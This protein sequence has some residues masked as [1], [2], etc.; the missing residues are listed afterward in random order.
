[1]VK[2]VNKVDQFKVYRR[3]I[4]LERL[5]IIANNDI[6]VVSPSTQDIQPNRQV[7]GWGNGLFSITFVHLGRNF[8]EA[9]LWSATHPHRRKWTEGITRRQ[10]LSREWSQFFET[11]YYPKAFSSPRTGRSASS[12]EFLLTHV[13]GCLIGTLDGDYLHDFRE[14]IREPIK[15][16]ALINDAQIDVLDDYGLLL[17]LSEG[18]V[19]TFPLHVLEAMYLLA[20]IAAHTSYFKSGVCV[21]R[22]DVCVFKARSAIEYD[23]PQRAR[24]KS[25]DV[26]TVAARRERYAVNLQGIL[27]PRAVELDSLPAHKALRG[28]RK[29]FAI[30][31]PKALDTQGLLG[32]PTNRSNLQG[33]KDNTRPK[34]VAIYRIENKI[35]P[36]YDGACVVA[37]RESKTEI[38]CLD[39]TEFA[40]YT[41][42]VDRG[43]LRG[44]D[45]VLHDHVRSPLRHA[46]K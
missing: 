44:A 36:C 26:P 46:P 30:I 16:S 13:G 6:C 5:L 4:P 10:D 33:G 9:T 45:V 23:R 7:R 17:V 27:R 34:P 28:V 41:E 35:F 42:G 31:Y 12:V 43:G 24:Q 21:G 2:E 32:P 3:P 25:A 11:T 20:G 40:F 38:N 18:Q 14:L 37:W 19:N 29:R 8:Y 22:T 39:S 15:A 1:M